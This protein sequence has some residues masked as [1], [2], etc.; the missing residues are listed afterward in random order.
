MA[1][2]RAIC[3]AA[4]ERHTN[5]TDIRTRPVGFQLAQRLAHESSDAG[6]SR[7]VHFS[8]CRQTFV[9]NTTHLFRFIAQL[10]ILQLTN[11]TL[12]LTIQNLLGEKYSGIAN[13]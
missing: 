3:D 4:V 8:P 10:I 7:A 9:W 1:S 11:N 2:T 6:V 5:K 13:D 12:M